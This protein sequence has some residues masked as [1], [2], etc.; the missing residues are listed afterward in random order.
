MRDLRDLPASWRLLTRALQILEQTYGPDHPEIASVLDSLGRVLRELGEP[1]TGKQASERA[2][3]ILLRVHGHDHY[4][5]AIVLHTQAL[6][7]RELGDAAAAR[8]MLERALRVFKTTLGPCHIDTLRA[9]R[10][11]QE[12]LESL[13][14]E[15]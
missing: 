3:Q 1:S 11:L 6:T 4:Q 9:K 14:Q 2:L 10:G 13:P 15:S 12:L 5:V 8:Q 7:L